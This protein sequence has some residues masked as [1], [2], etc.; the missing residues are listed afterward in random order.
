MVVLYDDKNNYLRIDSMA[1]QLPVLTT[2]QDVYV[3]FNWNICGYMPV[4]YGFSVY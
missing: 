3:P 4:E 2:W 1:S